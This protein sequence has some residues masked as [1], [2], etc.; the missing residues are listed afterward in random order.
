MNL[1]RYIELYDIF[2][3]LAPNPVAIT[4]G[5]KDRFFPIEGVNKAIPIIEKVYNE[6]NHPENILI[7]L[8]SEGHQFYGDKIYPFLINHI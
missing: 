2:S 8:Q 7:D 6:V 3:S 1:R 4:F 5:R